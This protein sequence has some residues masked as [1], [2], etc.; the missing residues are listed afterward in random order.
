MIDIEK[1][2]EEAIKSTLVV[3]N[4]DSIKYAVDKI[5]SIVFKAHEDGFY[6]GTKCKDEII[7][8]S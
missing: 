4:K 5:K 6:L 8:N 2:I 3:E 7:G 1:Q